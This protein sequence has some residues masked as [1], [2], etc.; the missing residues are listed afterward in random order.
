[1][2]AEEM[3]CSHTFSTGIRLRLE[4]KIIDG[5]ETCRVR[6]GLPVNL[7]YCNTTVLLNNKDPMPEK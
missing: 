5:G 3:V 4:F 6:V 1:M 2:F 7:F